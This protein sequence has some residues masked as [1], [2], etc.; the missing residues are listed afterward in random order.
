MQIGDFKILNFGSGLPGKKSASPDGDV[1]VP[2]GFGGICI[3]AKV[4]VLRTLLH[5]CCKCVA[6][7]SH[8]SQGWLIHFSKLARR[9]H[10]CSKLFQS[11]SWS[12]EKKEKP[13]TKATC[14]FSFSFPFPFSFHFSFFFSFSYP[15][16]FSYPFSFFFSSSLPLLLPLPL[17][18]SL[19]LSLVPCLFFVSFS[20]SYCMVRWK[21]TQSTCCYK[22]YKYYKFIGKKRV[23]IVFNCSQLQSLLKCGLFFPRKIF[24][25]PKFSEGIGIVWGGDRTLMRT[26]H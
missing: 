26:K 3:Q 16:Y 6:W 9:V 8:A 7:A 4:L 13:S 5:V 22:Y 20:L 25:A 1:R 2:T 11:W 15:F 12:Q 23:L 17:S 18:L 19:S 21:V 14:S 10:N 24:L